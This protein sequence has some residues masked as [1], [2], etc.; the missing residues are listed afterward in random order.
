MGRVNDR[1]GEGNV[2]IRSRD[3]GDVATSQRMLAATDTGRDKEQ[4]AL[5]ASRGSVALPTLVLAP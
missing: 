4:R 1:R 2:T 5:R 3:W